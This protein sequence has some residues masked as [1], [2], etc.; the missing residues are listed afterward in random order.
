MTNLL[1]KS[2]AILGK[3][4]PA[5]CLTTRRDLEPQP[6]R[7]G[8][9][10]A[11][12]SKRE[13]CACGCGG[14]PSHPRS[15]FVKGRNPGNVSLRQPCACGC[16]GYPSRAWFEF[17]RGHGPDQKGVPR[18]KTG[19]C[20]CGCGEIA[21]EC[22]GCHAFLHL[23]A[24]NK[25]PGGVCKVRSRCKPCESAKSAEWNDAH[26]EHRLDQHLRRR[27]GI[28]LIRYNEMLEAQNGCC[29]ICGDPPGVTFGRLSERR[30]GR[31][32]GRMRVPQLVVDHDHATGEVRG[33][34]CVP[35]NGGIGLLR[36]NPEVLRSALKYLEG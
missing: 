9:I 33:L 1:A 36:D 34:L 21:L 19:P 15:K 12:Q 25:H 8:E 23:S 14:Y 30:E 6:D 26:I 5:R 31:R 3:R 35:C 4:G 2:G 10:L 20:S 29:A 7:T 18:R 27:Y 13:P 16:G 11:D 28:T 32:Y 24:F 17:K 22:V